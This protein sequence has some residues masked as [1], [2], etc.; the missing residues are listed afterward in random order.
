MGSYK[1]IEGDLLELFEQGHFD[2]IGH[3]ANC[4]CRM[5]SGI[6]GQISK[7]YPEAVQQDNQTVPGDLSKLGNFT[8]AFYTDKDKF[9]FNLYT[10]YRYG[11]EPNV[12]YVSYEAIRESMI[13][14]REYLVQY[15]W[16]TPRV[17]FPLIGC[18]LAN[19]DW[20]IVSKI[21]KEVWN[22]CDVTIVH[23]NQN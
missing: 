11:R 15:T 19:G 9:I 5:K 3:G 13:A 14:M 20:D 2:A 10:Q 7:K 6:A 23:Y 22:D 8:K 18:G 16:N 12:L 17:G 4:F 21:I 1:E